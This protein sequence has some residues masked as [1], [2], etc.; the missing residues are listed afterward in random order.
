MIKTVTT[1]RIQLNRTRLIVIAELAVVVNNR[2]SPV[3][4]M[5]LVIMAGQRQLVAVV[6]LGKHQCTMSAYN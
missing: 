4:A 3:M 6:P 1:K 5:M 2:V